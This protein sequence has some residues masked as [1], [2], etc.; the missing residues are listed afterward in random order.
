MHA[1]HERGARAPLGWA[2]CTSTY[3]KAPGQQGQLQ[4]P[5]H[6]SANQDQTGAW[7]P[8]KK[9][10]AQLLV[11]Q[12]PQASPCQLA[13][14]GIHQPLRAVQRVGA[15]ALAWVCVPSLK[16]SWPL[17]QPLNLTHKQFQPLVSAASFPSS[18]PFEHGD[19]LQDRE[20]IPRLRKADCPSEVAQQSQGQNPGPAPS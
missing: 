13:S 4:G 15:E 10:A 8:L 18:I 2:P 16:H 19:S 9:P 14:R 1:G 3:P 7:H 17:Y 5:R 11:Q 6:W 12:G 20:Q